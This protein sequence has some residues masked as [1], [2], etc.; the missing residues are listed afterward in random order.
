MNSRLK[1]NHIENIYVLEFT[2]SLLKF[3]SGLVNP[4]FCF[5]TIVYYDT[6]VRGTRLTQVRKLR[7]HVYRILFFKRS[8]A[9]LDEIRVAYILF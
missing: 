6:S 9:R 3:W 2:V 8:A 4:V 1:L 7:S 5:H